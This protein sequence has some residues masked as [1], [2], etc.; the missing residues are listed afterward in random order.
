MSKQP[1]VVHPD[2]A[3]LNGFNATRVAALGPNTAYMNSNMSALPNRGASPVGI[4]VDVPDEAALDELLHV[5]GISRSPEEDIACARDLPDDETERQAVIAARRGQGQ[6]R[7]DLLRFWGVCAVTGCA[8]QVLLRASHIQPWRDSSNRERRD[9]EN[10]LLL[11]AHL[12]AAF[13]RGLISFADDGKIL[14]HPHRLLDD[15]A[16]ALGIHSGLRLR[17]LSAGHLRFLA[18]HRKM[19]GFGMNNREGSL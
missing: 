19:H 11:A 14:M 3:M 2:V 13:D 12:D 7:A 17:R 18:V 9:S 1:L 10:G 6:F 5:M 8:N 15:D 4:A 16:K